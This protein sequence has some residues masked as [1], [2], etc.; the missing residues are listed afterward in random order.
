[1]EQSQYDQIYNYIRSGELPS[2]RSKNEKDCLRRKSKT[3]CIKNGLLFYREK[4]RNVDL[5]VI[6]IVMHESRM[7][8]YHNAHDSWSRSIDDGGMLAGRM[9]VPKHA[10]CRPHVGHGGPVQA[11]ATKIKN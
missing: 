4:K 8:S 3:F 2:N 9:H 1:M 5:Q 7:V 6:V 10:T 11:C